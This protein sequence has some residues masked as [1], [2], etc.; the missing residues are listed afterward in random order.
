MTGTKKA[1]NIYHLA[2]CRESLPVSG[3][4]GGVRDGDSGGGGLGPRSGR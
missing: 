4:G 1:L 3:M 2:I